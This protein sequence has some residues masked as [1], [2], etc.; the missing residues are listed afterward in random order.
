VLVADGAEPC[1]WSE[2]EAVGDRDRGVEDPATTLEGPE[3]GMA[4]DATGVD[5]PSCR[6]VVLGEEEGARC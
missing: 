6:V 2:G 4:V 1:S 3:A 5:G